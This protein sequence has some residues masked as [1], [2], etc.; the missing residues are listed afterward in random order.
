MAT[1]TELREEEEVVQRRG[2]MH[3][4]LILFLVVVVLMVLLL[5]GYAGLHIT[6]DRNVVATAQPIAASTVARV[7]ALTQATTPPVVFAT[8]VVVATAPALMSPTIPVIVSSTDRPITVIPAAGFAVVTVTASDGVT[9]R[10][11]PS[12]ASV[13]AGQ[14]AVGS[15][16]TVIGADVLDPNSTSRWIHIRVGNIE[17]FVRSDLVNEPHAA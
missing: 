16:L 7:G 11:Q 12:I 5:I 1:M 4:V 14:A 10:S 8:P 17:G 15:D 13:A 9:I 6:V 2:G 3:S